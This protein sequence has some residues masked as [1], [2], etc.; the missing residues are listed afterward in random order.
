[1]TTEIVSAESQASL[2]VTWKLTELQMFKT[3]NE[4]RGIL[5]KNVLT[6]RLRQ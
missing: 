6:D 5:Y 4:Q 1:M 2:T 3:G